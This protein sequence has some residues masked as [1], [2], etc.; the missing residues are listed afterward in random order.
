LNWPELLPIEVCSFFSLSRETRVKIRNRV[1]GRVDSWWP[2]LSK[3][4]ETRGMW[5]HECFEYSLEKFY[6]YSSNQLSLRPFRSGVPSCTPRSLR[7][8][9]YLWPLGFHHSLAFLDSW[10]FLACMVEFLIG[11]NSELKLCGR[12]EKAICR[13]STGAQ[14]SIWT[15]AAWI[16]RGAPPER[17]FTFINY[18]FSTFL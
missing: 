14:W 16:R 7:R 13:G 8:Q 3:T 4:P 15:G 12:P 5:A 2:L 11:V 6:G 10:I 1:N 18:R 9:Q 17:Q